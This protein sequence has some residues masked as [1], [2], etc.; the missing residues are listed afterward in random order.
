MWYIK[1]KALDFLLEASRNNFPNE[2]AGML[3]AQGNVITEILVIPRTEWNNR[4]ALI[5]LDMLPADP[6]IVGSVH[7]HPGPAIPSQADLEFF[8]KFGKIHIIVGYPFRETDIRAYLPS[9]EP[10]PVGIKD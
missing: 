10:T 7:S 8:S 6:S 9:G 2:F 1:R 4:S 5:F 3:R